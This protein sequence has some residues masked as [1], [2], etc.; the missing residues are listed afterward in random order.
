MR[1][2]EPDTAECGDR[3]DQQAQGDVF[4]EQHDAA[5]RCDDRYRQFAPFGL[6]YVGKPFGPVIAQLA[7]WSYQL[8]DAF[9]VSRL[10]RKL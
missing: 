10:N 6:D 2:D 7:Y 9:Q 8:Q 5:E 1:E 4:R 3:R